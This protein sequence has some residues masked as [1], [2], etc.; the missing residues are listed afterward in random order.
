MESAK[1]DDKV[2]PLDLS[3]SNDDSLVDFKSPKSD[4]AV[5]AASS[6][7]VNDKRVKKPSAK[8]KKTKESRGSNRQLP[9]PSIESSFFKAAI[10]SNKNEAGYTCPLCIKRF[11]DAIL[12]VAHTKSCASKNK[13]SS[14]KLLAA[15]ALQERQ[16]NERLAIGLPIGP[17]VQTKPKIPRQNRARVIIHQVFVKFSSCIVILA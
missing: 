4:S 16:G 14:E 17:L 12:G 3:S 8:G 15:V 9:Q 2:S 6:K 7:I 13:V 10:N 11:T 5:Q 1:N